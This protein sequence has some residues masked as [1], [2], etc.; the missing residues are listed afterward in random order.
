M[1]AAPDKTL[2]IVIVNWNSCAFLRNCLKSIYA[3]AGDLPLEVIV[4]DNASYDGSKKIVDEEFPKVRFVQSDTN[5]GFAGANNLGF[6]YSSGRSLLFLNPDTEIVG[7]ALQVMLASLKAAPDA[8]IIGP[9]L[10]NSDLSV[11]T[12]CIQRFPTI[13]N[14]LL[15]CEYLRTKFPRAGIWGMRP[16]WE[17]SDAAVEI[18]AV[19]GACLMVRRDAFEKVG[20]FSPRYFMYSEDVDL[21]YEVRE[22]AW[23]VYFA[24]SATV[25]HHGGRSSS[26]SAERHFADV[27]ARESIY[28][29]LGAK[30][31]RGYAILYRAA[32]AMAALSRLTLLGLTFAPIVNN[33]NQACS[34]SASRWR[35]ILEWS[36]GRVRWAKDVQTP[37]PALQTQ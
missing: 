9:K 34:A 8:G 10:L 33:K 28:R 14:Q 11:Q 5:L 30:R 36:L 2:S 21:C 35:S 17:R 37:P 24:D 32:I 31:G 29:F 1:T 13:L 18:D 22:S 26:A 20:M 19:S 4:V 23:K 27:M 6:K 15:D 16:L 25:I 12:S 3:T 7:T